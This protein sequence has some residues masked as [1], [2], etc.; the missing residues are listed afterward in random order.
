ML[1]HGPV[2]VPADAPRG[3]ALVRVELPK[4]S[5]FESF[6]TELEVMIE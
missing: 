6:P 1:C 4:S 3:K 2:W 5:A